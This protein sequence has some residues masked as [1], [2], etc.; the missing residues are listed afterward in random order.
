LKSESKNR[1]VFEGHWRDASKDKYFGGFTN[2]SFDYH[3]NQI[4]F[5]WNYARTEIKM[6][7]VGGLVGVLSEKDKSLL[8]IFGYSVMEN[9][10]IEK[11]KPRN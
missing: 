10:K 6:L 8:P 1:Y 7:L 5:I 2:S 9:K 4:P 3:M 11:K